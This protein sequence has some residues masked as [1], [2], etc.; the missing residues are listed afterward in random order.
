MIFAQRLFVVIC[1]ALF[2]SG[3]AC[4]E[5][6]G[7]DC[8]PKGLIAKGKEAWNP[9]AFW[10]IQ[11]KEIKEYVE[12]Q[13]TAYRLSTIE[14]KRDKI[15]ERLDDEEMK[16]MGI[17]QYSDP[18]LDR[19]INKIDRELLQMERKMLNEAIEWGCKCTEHAKRKLSQAK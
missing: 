3:H 12:A 1:F 7:P 5:G 9:K 11:I 19:E 17:E 18:E 4:A 15:N 6:L 2:F 14:R 16:A 10:T 8:E 13:K